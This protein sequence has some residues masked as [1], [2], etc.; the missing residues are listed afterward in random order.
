[1]HRLATFFWIALLTATSLQ[2]LRPKP[3]AP[4]H[5]PFHFV[6]FTV[7]AVLMHKRAAI[8]FPATILFGVALELAQS[9]L[10]H[11]PVEWWDIRDDALGALVGVML[12]AAIVKRSH[13]PRQKQT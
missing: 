13:V 9:L 3:V 11:N 8:A 2:P 4:L 1:M 12:S 5:R 6:A 10:Y 7:T